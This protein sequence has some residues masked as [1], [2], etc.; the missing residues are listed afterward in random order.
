MRFLPCLWE[1]WK[2]ICPSILTMLSVFVPTW[3]PTVAN[4]S[5]WKVAVIW[6]CSILPKGIWAL[7]DAIPFRVA[8]WNIRCLSSRW[9]SS[10]SIPAVMWIG[11]GILW[12]LRWAWRLR[13]VC[14][15]LWPMVTGTVRAW[16]TS[17]FPFPSRTGLTLPIWYSIFRR[18][19][20]PQ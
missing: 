5:N 9:R 3:V 14:V 16:W 10:S 12:I 8:S 2:C 17:M 20:M 11:G 6:I 4:T 13:N 15:L 7:P 1:D 18:P 19:K